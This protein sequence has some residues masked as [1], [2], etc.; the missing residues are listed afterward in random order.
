MTPHVEDAFAKILGR[1]PSETERVRLQ[2]V[3]DALGLRDNDAFWY[4]VMILEHYD[5]LYR[6]YPRQIAEEARR[7]IEQARA[8]FASAAQAEAA[9][10]QRLL[11][12]QMGRGSA[13]SREA[14]GERPV[15]AAAVTGLV[16]LAVVF[17]ALCV[18]AGFKL[19]SGPVPFWAAPQR[20]PLTMYGAIAIALRV[21]AGWMLVALLVPAGAAGARSGW[22]MATMSDGDR[23]QK[24]IGSL[25][26]VLSIA[27]A[28][29]LA[30]A[31]VR[32]M[33][34]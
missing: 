8:A 29:S 26:C 16:A 21:P 19:A 3:R 11:L 31:I 25:L 6:D 9:K 24:L 27:G 22:R 7:V 23:G 10:A 15:V 30:V 13:E 4:I 1:Q 12:Q 5:A 32:L 2:R 18:T 20:L 33:G 14:R 28:S 34:G 17:G